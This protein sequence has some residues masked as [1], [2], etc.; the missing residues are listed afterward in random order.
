MRDGQWRPIAL[1][2]GAKRDPIPRP[3]KFIETNS[4]YAIIRAIMY[5]HLNIY[6]KFL[7]F[8]EK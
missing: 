8:R 5:H 3:F 4:F 1:T 6:Y 2:Q 7:P